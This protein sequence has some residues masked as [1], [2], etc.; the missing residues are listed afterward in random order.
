MKKILIISHN[1][2]SNHANNGKTLNSF[3]EH[4]KSNEVTQLYFQDEI[5][6]SDKFKSFYRLRDTDIL[7]SFISFKKP[8]GVIYPKTR[9]VNHRENTSKFNQVL[10]GILKKLEKPKKIFRELIYNQF[11]FSLRGA[12]EW[13]ENTRPQA[14]FLMGSEY[15]FLYRVGSHIAKKYNIPLYLYITDD[16][17]L[18]Y[19]SSGFINNYFNTKLR[20]EISNT[21]KVAKNCFA[22]GEDMANAYKKEFTVNFDI[23]CNCIYFKEQP[24]PKIYTNSLTNTIIYAG[25]LTLGRGRMISE[26]MKLALQASKSI[27]KSIHLIVY[28]QD[29][30]DTETLKEFKNNKIDFLGKLDQSS[31]K[32]NLTKADYLLH[33]ESDSLNH[34]NKTKLS[35]STKIPEYLS[36]GIC[37]IA[38]GPLELSSIKLF[39]KNKIGIC[40]NSRD[41]ATKNIQILEGVLDNL[42]ICQELSTNACKYVYNNFNADYIQKLIDN[43]IFNE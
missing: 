41:N 39:T 38:F 11:K 18:N 32:K 37:T 3:F 26:F 20:R 1:S 14:I 23:L 10:I 34:T 8:G 19:K 42:N 16:Y 9:V 12:Y 24:K 33:V 4:R 5:P 17:I 35:I 21:I 27:K 6:E 7:K 30:P 31:L 29:S 15:P 2:L 40:I 22:I 25:G 36:T 13:I 28:S 43:K